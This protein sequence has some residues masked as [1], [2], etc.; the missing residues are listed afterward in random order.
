MTDIITRARTW[1][2]TGY[3]CGTYTVWGHMMGVK[4]F[5]VDHP[6]DVG[7]LRQVFD[8]LAAVPEW[9]PRMS[10]MASLSPAW[11]AIASGWPDLRKYPAGILKIV[12]QP[13]GDEDRMIFRMTAMMA[14]SYQPKPDWKDLEER[15]AKMTFD[16]RVNSW[17]VGGD[18]GLSST[19]IWAVMLGLDAAVG[20]HP[21]DPADLGRCL[22]L[23]ELM[24][25]WRH[26]LQE[27]AD[28]SPEWK[29]LT[30]RWDEL[31]SSME[32]EVGIAWEKGR[33][34][35]KTYELM[36]DI[37]GRFERKTS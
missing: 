36:R 33:S 9:E 26:R 15:Y 34:A 12:E 8:L 35:P 4:D 28:L 18:T 13:R 16:E 31:A 25:E 7:D 32:K 37:L 6:T 2:A 22:R 19:T 27:L 23:L 17:I 3:G 20:N 1:I 10:E 11:A 24:P 30:F 29:K 5:Y 14:R 21:H